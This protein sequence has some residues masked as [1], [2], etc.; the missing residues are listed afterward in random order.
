VWQRDLSERVS[1]R[2]V[3]EF[4]RE[5]FWAGS[6]AGTIVYGG[7]GADTGA[8]RSAG[9]AIINYDPFTCGR[10]GSGRGAKSGA[11]C[12][13]H[14]S[15]LT[16][17]LAAWSWGVSGIINVIAASGGAVLKAGAIGV[18]G[19]SR[20]WKGAFVVGALHDRVALMLPVESG[21]GGAG[22]WRCIAK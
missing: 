19:C 3:S 13:V 5:L 8:M 4:H 16:G 6:S 10:E 11:Y 22:C 20:Y 14:G 9:A 7:F 1:R 21:T 15:S 12:T 2:E 17:Y 18:S